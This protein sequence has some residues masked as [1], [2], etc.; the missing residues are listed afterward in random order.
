MKVCAVEGCDRRVKAKGYCASHYQNF[1]RLGK[2]ETGTRPVADRFWE[3]VDRRGEDDCWLWTGAL[4]KGYGHMLG[5]RGKSLRAH[6]VAYEL[7]VGR[8]PDG[9]ELDHLCRNPKCVN[10]AH[11]E[12]VSHAENIRRANI[13]RDETGRFT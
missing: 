13:P 10:P 12:P 6:R 2:P 1:R 3:K 11:L 4:Q 8:I 5:V 9:C 7:L